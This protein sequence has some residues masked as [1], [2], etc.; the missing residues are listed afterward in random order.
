MVSAWP[1]ESCSENEL[2]PWS[3]TP[4]TESG[5]AP[6]D[7]AVASTCTV[8]SRKEAFFFDI[9]VDLSTVKKKS[10]V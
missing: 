3:V 5:V 2:S 4:S 8:K 9:Q 10:P 1:V 6:N 7:T